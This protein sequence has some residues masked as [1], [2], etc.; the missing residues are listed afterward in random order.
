MEERWGDVNGTH[1]HTNTQEKISK[2]GKFFARFQLSVLSQGMKIEFFHLTLRGKRIPILKK[3][4]NFIAT[5][6]KKS[7]KASLTRKMSKRASSF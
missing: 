4:Y 7:F 6:Y 2:R 5:T 3:F 1:S